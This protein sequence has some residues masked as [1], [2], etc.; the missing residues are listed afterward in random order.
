MSLG[1]IQRER[2]AYGRVRADEKGAERG[3]WWERA[4]KRN[5]QQSVSSLLT[6][7]FSFAGVCGPVGA[8]T[9]FSKGFAGQ[10]L[11]CD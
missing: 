9:L 11:T 6:S 1:I 4:R 3:E 10:I 2:T 5:P 7:S 8:H